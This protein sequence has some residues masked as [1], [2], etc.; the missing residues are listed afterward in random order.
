MAAQSPVVDAPRLAAL[1]RRPRYGPDRRGRGC[2]RRPGRGTAQ[3]AALAEAQAAFDADA[4]ELAADRQDLKARTSSVAQ[5]ETKLED[6]EAAEAALLESGG[7]ES[8]DDGS[9]DTGGST[10]YENCDAARAAGAAPVY[11]GD[12]GYGSHLDRDGDG[13][14]CE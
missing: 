5:K 2:R 13:V 1:G 14:G 11:S 3:A 7:G 8:S 10:Y 9:A 4:A 6:R 12:P